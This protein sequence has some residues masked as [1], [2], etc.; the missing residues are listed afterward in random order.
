M[1]RWLLVLA[2]LGCAVSGIDL[3]GKE[4]P[5]VEGWECDVVSNVCVRA[6]AADGG[7]TSGQAPRFVID[8]VSADWAT[9]N[10]IH[11][12]W[13]A[14]GAAEDFFAFE[15]RLATS[16][17]ALDDGTDVLL[18]DRDTNPELGRYVLDDTRG[19]DL[20]R[21]TV[22]D[23]LEPM[24]DYY[25]RLTVLDTAGGQVSSSN[26]AVDSTPPLAT[27]A[28][29]IF[30]EQPPAGFAAPPC[31]SR[32]DDAAF[33]GEFAYSIN[34]AC[35]AI[36]ALGCSGQPAQAE[37]FDFVRWQGLGVD[38]GVGLG[39]GAFANAYL[40]FSLA[41][42]P[43]PE[44]PGEAWWTQIRVMG[45]DGSLGSYQPGPVFRADGMYRMY[46]IPLPQFGLTDSQLGSMLRELHIGSSWDTGSTIRVDEARLRW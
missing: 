18:F 11:W 35:E 36:D 30:S 28:V 10:S 1:R 16:T 12:V 17:A 31:F 42:E 32:S 38:L 9:P 2:P 23:G 43:P 3:D 22:T 46:Q 27:Q 21:G 20:V 25:A 37:C 13:D 5:C 26:I 39:G 24:T 44:L 6:A 19:V 15:I 8:S 33:D 45:E 7:G 34:V 41:I 14:Q 29:V 40:E 4:C